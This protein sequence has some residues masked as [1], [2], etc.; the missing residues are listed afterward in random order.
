MDE[1]LNTLRR[2]PLFQSISPEILKQINTLS[3]KRFFKKNR[4]IFI[5]GDSADCFYIIL[6]GWVK[7]Y[8]ISKEGN[9]VI[10]HVFGPGES[11]AEA[12]VF[13]ERRIYPVY[14]EAIEDAELIEIS[15]QFFVNKIIED[16]NFA[17][18]MLASIAS[19]QHFLVQQI[20]QVTTRS[21]SQR[22]GS[23]MI[24]FCRKTENKK[25]NH[26]LVDLPYD[27]S[28]ICSRLN[29]KPETFSRAL[30]KLEEHGVKQENRR[31]LIVDMESLINFC[32]ISPNDVYC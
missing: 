3:N 17:L 18:S 4:E 15:R 30:H 21:A 13:S 29:I 5:Q 23:F 16:S 32:D 20:E 26:W 6:K 9:E 27:K 31:I 12:A 25:E 2:T 28:V 7:L 1:I 11:F 10:I 8:R 24:R 22:I 19:R 14:A